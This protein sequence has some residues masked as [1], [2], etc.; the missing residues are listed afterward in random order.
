[1]NIVKLIEKLNAETVELAY[2]FHGPERFL[3]DQAVAKLKGIVLSSAM[4]DFNL[5]ELDGASCSADTVVNQAMQIPMMASRSLVVVSLC[6]PSRS[7]RR[8]VCRSSLGSRRRRCC[9]HSPGGDW[10]TG[11]PGGLC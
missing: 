9:L 4:S 5:H 3:I 1:M 2:L 8:H 6:E 10:L 7:A 11:A